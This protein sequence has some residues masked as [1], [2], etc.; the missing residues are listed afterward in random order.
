MQGGASDLTLTD[1]N[2]NGPSFKDMKC[3]RPT[4]KLIRDC[5]ARRCFRPDT[6]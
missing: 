1:C 4:V 6:D 5:D 3:V 2:M